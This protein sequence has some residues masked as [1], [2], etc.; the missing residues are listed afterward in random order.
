MDGGLGSPFSLN[1]HESL[2]LGYVSLV[3]D[4]LLGGD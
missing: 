3:Q 1:L 4:D 2:T